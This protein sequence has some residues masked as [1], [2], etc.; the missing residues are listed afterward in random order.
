MHTRILAAALLFCAPLAAS[1]AQSLDVNH[2]NFVSYDVNPDKCTVTKSDGVYYGT[3]SSGSAV[4][5]L[6]D[7]SVATIVFAGNWY[8][9]SSANSPALC[10]DARAAFF[11][12]EQVKHLIDTLDSIQAG[13]V[14]FAGGDKPY[15]ATESLRIFD[16]TNLRAIPVG[17][18]EVVR[19]PAACPQ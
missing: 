18:F 8:N 10:G 1:A 2:V 16:G 6:K 13:Q 5:K 3:I 17:D 9:D 7:G 19:T 12:D 4:V 15:C 14:V 11:A